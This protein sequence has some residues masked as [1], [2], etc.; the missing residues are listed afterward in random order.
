M[1]I[2]WCSCVA[3]RTA[4][5]VHKSIL[6]SLSTHYMRKACRPIRLCFLFSLCLKQS[7]RKVEV[8]NVVI[9]LS[10]FSHTYVCM[11]TARIGP[12]LSFRYAGFNIPDVF[13]YVVF[14][15]WVREFVMEIFRIS[16][17][18]DSSHPLLDQRL[19]QYK[20]HRP[21]AWDVF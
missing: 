4:C 13:V 1:R 10:A 3:P 17:L 6:I 7:V 14:T 9:P 12:S 19:W 15:A 21:Q 20:Q 11:Y 2:I 8:E 18:C 5:A 16:V